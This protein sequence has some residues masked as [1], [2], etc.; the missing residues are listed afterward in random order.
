M[1]KK[2]NLILLIIIIG[3]FLLR[4]WDVTN[5][6]A[7]FNADEAAIGY[8]AYS[9][10]QTGK[11][12]YGSILPLTFK[13][14]GDYK[15]GLYVYF[16]LPFVA[17][18]GLTEL[19]VRLPSVL[20]GTATVLLLYVI[21]KKIFDRRVGLIAAFLLAITPWQIT[22]SRGGWETN[23]A[24]FFVGLGVYLFLIS[25]DKQKFIFWS[26]LSFLVSIY[27][28]Q[29]TRLTAPLLILG[30]IVIYFGKIRKFDFKKLIIYG[31]ILGLLSIPLV[32]EFVG[33][34]GASRFSGLSFLS[35]PGPS[36]R[37]NQ[38][39]GEHSNP[40]NKVVVALHNKIT[41]YVPNFL[42]HYLDHFSPNFLFINGDPIIR[43]LVP[44]TGQLYLIEALFIAAGI[45]TLAYRRQP[46]FGL[47]LIWLLTAPIASSLTYQTPNGVRALGM[48]LPLTLIGAYGM[49]V[50]I[51]H[52]R[53]K[54]LK[55][56]IVVVI[57]MILTFEFS[58]F[59]ESYFVHYPKRYPLAWE[60]GFKEMV[61]KLEKYQGQYNNVVITDRYD[62]PYILVLFYEKYNPAKYQPQAVLSARD[63]FN[64]GTVRAFDKY[65]FRPIEPTD[66]EKNTR[67]LFVGT[68]KE[69]PTDVS[70][71]DKVYYPNG[72]IAFVFAK[73]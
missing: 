56:L 17:L 41:A 58:H 10:L 70:I 21:A 32:L 61:S 46:F 51:E 43:N 12:E 27:M 64:F 23:V 44:E 45:I 19:A 14:F 29:S 50:I 73:K 55:A 47:I 65:Q 4:F 53:G 38:L 42:G 31:V 60:Y 35:D 36:T 26:F 24:T 30:L 37:V 1:T 25:L 62:Q 34:T 3:A 54:Y 48:V 13:S 67:T 2:I 72:E 16:V 6:P 40:N 52:F 49:N 66:F 20:F 71:I 7:G 39:R 59:L 28:Y 57:F 5:Y 33:G 15:P 69:I 11:D 8:N 22:F 68:P 9:I 63:K 18:L